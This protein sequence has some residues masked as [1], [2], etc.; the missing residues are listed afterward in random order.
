MFEDSEDE[1]TVDDHLENS[2]VG[3]TDMIHPVVPEDQWMH[4]HARVKK[5]IRGATETNELSAWNEFKGQLTL[6]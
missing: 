3:E 1:E 2:Y 5:Y 6:I 4:E